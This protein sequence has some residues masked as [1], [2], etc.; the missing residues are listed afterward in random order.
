MHAPSRSTRTRAPQNTTAT[1]W[2]MLHSCKRHT[3]LPHGFCSRASTVTHIRNN[4]PG[5]EVVLIFCKEFMCNSI[6]MYWTRICFCCTTPS[7][8]I[9]V[10]RCCTGVMSTLAC[11]TTCN[12]MLGHC[13]RLPGPLKGGRR[14][15]SSPPR[16]FSTCPPALCDHCRRLAMP[17]V[18]CL[19]V[20]VTPP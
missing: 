19:P 14:I 18:V 8:I 11:T 16:S 3:P 7:D 10:E 5:L 2:L 13:S 9:L 1:A 6:D 4:I 12:G 20:H 15:M 17:A